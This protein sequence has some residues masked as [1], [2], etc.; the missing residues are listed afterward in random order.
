MTDLKVG[1]YVVCHLSDGVIVA[2]SDGF[3][4]VEEFVI[5]STDSYGYYLYVPSYIHLN[6]SSLADSARCHKLGIE[7][8]FVDEQIVYITAGLVCKEIKRDGSRC[9]RCTDFVLMAT[10]NQDD[11]TFCCRSCREN[12]WR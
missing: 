1:D 6:G 3:Q 11:G 7:Y 12:R 4:L 2:P 9:A 5:V 8:R 10:P